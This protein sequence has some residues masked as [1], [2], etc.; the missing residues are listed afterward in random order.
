MPK[1]PIAS[2]HI[3]SIYRSAF[4]MVCFG[5]SEG[6][7]CTNDFPKVPPLIFLKTPAALPPP[8]YTKHNN[9]TN[10]QPYKTI[11]NTYKN[12]VFGGMENKYSTARRPQE[13][14]VSSTTPP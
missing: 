14:R 9:L 5:A 10:T 6:K 7:T 11:I 12:R 3:Y 1:S 2:S 13:L 4:P 8:P